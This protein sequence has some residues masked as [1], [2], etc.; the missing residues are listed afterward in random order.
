MSVFV[1]QGSKITA[2][3]QPMVWRAANVLIL[4]R[5]IPKWLMVPKN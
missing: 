5:L 4:Y 2:V 3:C 1:W